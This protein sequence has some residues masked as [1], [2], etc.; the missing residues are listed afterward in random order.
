MSRAR[1][2]ANYGDGVEAADL[3]ST[4]DLTGK[5]VTLPAG[6]G[7][8]VLQVVHTAKTD[9]QV[10]SFGANTYGEVTDLRTTITPTSASSKILIQVTLGRIAGNSNGGLVAITRNDGDITDVG[11]AVGS[12]RQHQM[13]WNDYNNNSD[14]TESTVTGLFYDEPNSTSLQ[15]YKIL[16]MGEGGTIYLNRNIAY[17]DTN[18]A[19][20]GITASTVVIYEV[21]MQP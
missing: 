9:P 15:T 17:E 12:R 20:R 8:K 21:D 1:T 14:W 5:T 13:F 3:S 4:L 11:D 16:L 6:T 18:I 2:V 19:Y 10:Y 7:G